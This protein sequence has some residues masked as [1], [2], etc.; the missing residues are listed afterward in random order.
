MDEDKI[1]NQ[2]KKNKEKT[3]RLKMVEDKKQKEKKVEEKK[4][5]IGIKEGE[6]KEYIV[7]LRKKF[8]KTPRYKRVPRA[9]KTLKKFIARH[10]KIRDGDMKKIK[11]NKYLN[12]EM[13]FKG[14]KNPPNKIKVKVRKDGENVIVELAELSEKSK[15]KKLKEEKVKEEAKKKKKDIEAEKKAKEEAKKKAEEEKKEEEKEKEKA[16][17]EAGLK[18]AGKKAKEIRHEVKEK[19][20]KHQVRKALEK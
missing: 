2:T 7:P 6:S 19:K 16:T 3:S 12:E 1:K 20:V 8:L 9:I 13:W 10:M 11:I 18:E 15:W 14:I 17:M 5:E 4:E